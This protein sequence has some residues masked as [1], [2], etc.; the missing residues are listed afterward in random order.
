[1]QR[2]LKGVDPNSVCISEL[3]LK[4]YVADLMRSYTP[5]SGKVIILSDDFFRLGRMLDC[6]GPQRDS[7]RKSSAESD[8]VIGDSI[9]RQAERC[10]R[11]EDWLNKRFP[12]RPFNPSLRAFFV[13]QNLL[14][15]LVQDATSFKKGDAMDFCHAVMATAFASFATLDT[16]WKHRVESLPK[17]NELARIY[18]PSELDQMVTD[19]EFWV[20]HRAA[21]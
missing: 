9:T 21:S 8:Q 5:G 13:F 18:S 7:I 19:M 3:F 4:S 12:R 20:A 16:C 2:E 14:R 10:K 11:E 6:M 15:I 17:P 1:M